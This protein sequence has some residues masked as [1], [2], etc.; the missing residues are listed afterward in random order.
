M[1]VLQSTNRTIHSAEAALLK[2]QIYIHAFLLSRLREIYEIHDQMVAWISSYFSDRQQRVNIKCK[3]WC[4][5]WIA[6][7]SW[8]RTCA[9][10]ALLH[11]THIYIVIKKQYCF[12]KKLSDVEDSVSEIKFAI[13]LN[14]D[15]IEFMSKRNVYMSAEESIQAGVLLSKL[16]LKLKI[17]ELFSMQRHVN[18]VAKAEYREFDVF[19]DR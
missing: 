14:G 11:D 10:L 18:I 16:D 9:D 19:L 3:L 7:T 17:L 1:D 13:K 6:C 4:T 8:M 15:K 5:S 2:V 12:T